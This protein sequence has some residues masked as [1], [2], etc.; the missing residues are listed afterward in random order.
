MK[1]DPTISR[2]REARKKISARFGHSAEKLG[3]HYMKLQEKCGRK[4]I[5]TSVSHAHN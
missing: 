5:K 2:I 3:R 1:D 4:L